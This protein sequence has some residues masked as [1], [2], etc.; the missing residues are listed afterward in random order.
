MKK[1]LPG[2]NICIG[3]LPL[4]FSLQLYVIF[5]NYL[6]HDYII[7]VTLIIIVMSLFKSLSCFDKV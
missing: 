1:V 6:P 7:Y 5:L 2:K 3:Q 4:L